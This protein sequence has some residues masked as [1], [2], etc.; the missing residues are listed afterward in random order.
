MESRQNPKIWAERS[1]K[2]CVR[3]F[4]H[5]LTFHFFA[6]SYL[7]G[8]LYLSLPRLL[9]LSRLPHTNIHTVYLYDRQALSCILL[10]LLPVF[11]VVLVVFGKRTKTQTAVSELKQIHTRLE[12]WARDEP[13]CAIRTV[14]C[15]M[16]SILTFFV[17]VR[18]RVRSMVTTG[19]TEFEQQAL[20]MCM[21]VT[22]AV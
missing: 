1:V 7:L 2:M 9:L 15:R 11:D 17:V 5:T 16:T 19:L 21:T 6:I 3:L 20:S 13:K 18:D 12:L 4:T 22:V 10:V 8:V 14:S